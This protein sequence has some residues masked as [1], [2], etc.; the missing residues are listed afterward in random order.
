MLHSRGFEIRVITDDGVLEEYGTRVTGASVHCH[1]PSQANQSFRFELKNHSYMNITFWCYA[2]GICIGGRLCKP[3]GTSQ[4]SRFV[5]SHS[6]ARPFT[7]AAVELSESSDAVATDPANI[8]S[9]GTI[10]VKVIRVKPC[11]RTERTY[12]VPALLNGPIDEKSKKIGTHH[13][14]LGP[15]IPLKASH[16]I[17][18]SEE[19]DSESQPFAEFIFQYRP[20]AS[21]QAQ[22]IIP[23]TPGPSLEGPPSQGSNN[24][25]RSPN[26]PI[27]GPSDVVR[28]AIVTPPPVPVIAREIDVKPATEIE[29]ATG[30]HDE[31]L[32][33]LEEQAHLLK[34]QAENV[35][36]RL[37]RIRARRVRT[38]KQQRL[39]LS[40]STRGS[41]QEP[42]EV[43]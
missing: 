26:S 19:I 35:Q 33:L 20:K 7:F 9:L 38:Q 3:Q 42:I 12:E 28:N 15:E 41:R 11:G 37:N 14:I 31:E 17:Y 10:T 34:M 32:A 2:D 5:V 16:N 36:E 4:L 23:V 8:T 13:V 27:P 29:N 40:P 25:D 1:I 24:G 30:N 22:G 43:D 39:S 6:V 21:L 18:L